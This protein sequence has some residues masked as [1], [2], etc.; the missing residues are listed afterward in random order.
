MTATERIEQLKKERRNELRSKELAAQA[1]A[2]ERRL[3]E[4]REVQSLLPIEEQWLMEFF[5]HTK[6]IDGC[7]YAR[8]CVPA[9]ADL[10]LRI[11]DGTNYQRYYNS[12]W[13]WGHCDGPEPCDCLADALIAAEYTV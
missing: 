13:Y 12:G 9:H 8:F 6:Y 11:T 7:K 3:S 4:Q 2:D 10:L 5:Q 1:E